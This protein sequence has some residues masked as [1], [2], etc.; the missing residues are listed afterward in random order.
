MKSREEIQ[1]KKRS[2][3]LGLCSSL[4][5]ASRLREC[6]SAPGCQKHEL[7]RNQRVLIR[8][9]YLSI[10][11]EAS[12]LYAER[13]DDGNMQHRLKVEIGK[14][15][16]LCYRDHLRRHLDTFLNLDQGTQRLTLA[17]SLYGR[18]R[19]ACRIKG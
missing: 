13:G 12:N 5:K 6:N 4:T 15:S 1:A 2:E 8:L 19:I 7:N 11:F 10:N 14:I 18:H 3:M 16:L 17:S 9:L